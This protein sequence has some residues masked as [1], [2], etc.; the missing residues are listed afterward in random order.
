MFSER[1]R[2]Q[3]EASDKFQHKPGYGRQYTNIYQDRL[4][5]LKKYIEVTSDWKQLADAKERVLDLQ[6]G[7][8]AYCTG[9]I[10][11]KP[12]NKTNIFN[13]LKKT[14]HGVKPDQPL[15]YTTDKDEIYLEDE[16]GRILLAGALCDKE[17]L[18]TGI[19]ASILGMQTTNGVFDA[20]DIAYPSLAP[21][22]D[23]STEIH[24]KVAILS[25]LNLDDV[26][27]E[28]LRITTLLEHLALTPE[29]VA[30]IICGNSVKSADPTLVGS[31]ML[32][33]PVN[34]A[35]MSKLDLLLASF[36]RVLPVFL[37]PGESDP[38]STA[39]PQISIH[40]TLFNECRPLI[41]DKTLNM[42]TNPQFLNFQGINMLG[43]SNQSI[44]DLHR[45]DHNDVF[46]DLDLM[47]K[48]LN[49]R[50]IAPTSPD[51]LWSFPYLEDPLILQELPHLYFVGNASA[52]KEREFGSEKK[53]KLLTVPSFSSTG[54]VAV[55]DLNSMTIESL[56]IKD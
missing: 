44:D 29:I 46:S 6:I 56:E 50:H 13:D 30:L 26:D 49:W 34:G 41:A 8:L 53:V 51:T 19:V 21:I 1:I 32:R 20:V 11:R 42:G 54:I 18:V 35:A 47:E 2:I 4:K 9:V 55:V 27:H 31:R 5:V 16:H 14:Y 17:F 52:L 10:V 36:C 3:V 28:D 22:S 25:G 40:P 43:I 39:F 7:K 37:M 45:Y 24:G 38:T 48:T 23:I 15:K 33:S 12:A